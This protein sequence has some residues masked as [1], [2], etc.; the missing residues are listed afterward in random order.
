M[1]WI[2]MKLLLCILLLKSMM[3]VLELERVGV[4]VVT[5]MS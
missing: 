2:C 3:D 1:I 5:N 4:T